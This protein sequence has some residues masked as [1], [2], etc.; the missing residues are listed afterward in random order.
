M[1]SRGV[2]DWVQVSLELLEHAREHV[3]SNASNG[4]YIP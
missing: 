1:S 3:Y 4:I 2:N